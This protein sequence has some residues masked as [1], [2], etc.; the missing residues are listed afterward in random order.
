MG[1]GLGY[2][3]PNPNPNPNQNYEC[4]RDEPGR[5]GEQIAYGNAGVMLLHVARM[6]ATQA[7]L[8]A[9]IRV[10]VRA[11]ARVRVRVSEEAARLGEASLRTLSA[12]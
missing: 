3:N 6:R 1:L 11:R 12:G 10:R 2:P 4:C 8:A 9:W 7:E 5:T